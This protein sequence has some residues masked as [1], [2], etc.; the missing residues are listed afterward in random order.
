MQASPGCV[1]RHQVVINFSSNRCYTKPVHPRILHAACGP[2]IVF[3][4]P[5]DADVDSRPDCYR[6]HKE[7]CPD[8]EEELKDVLAFRLSLDPAA[9]GKIIKYAKHYEANIY[10]NPARVLCRIESWLPLEEE[11]PGTDVRRL[12]ALNPQLITYKAP[13]LRAKLTGLLTTFQLQDDTS[14]LAQYTT[15]CSTLLTRST[16]SISEHINLLQ[17]CLGADVAPA[18]IGRYPE[19]LSRD[20]KGLVAAFDELATALGG[21]VYTAQRMVNSNPALLKQRNVG[22][23]LEQLA[24]TVNISVEDVRICL[25]PL[26]AV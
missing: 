25:T 14:K 9:T 7:W 20:A 17:S 16:E 24:S 10:K 22:E 26:H 12:L 3:S 21:N 11:F 15:R 6:V 2:R 4:V 19:L 8:A 18:V 23:R 1:H 5:V 13:A